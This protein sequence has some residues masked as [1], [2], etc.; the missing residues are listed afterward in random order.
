MLFV[1]LFINKG[2]SS[3]DVPV[4]L[5]CL[6]EMLKKRRKQVGKLQRLEI[7]KSLEDSNNCM[8][9]QAHTT[10]ILF[11]LSWPSVW[12]AESSHNVSL[13]TVYGVSGF[14]G[15][16]F[17][18]QTVVHLIEIERLVK[19]QFFASTQLFS[20]LAPFHYLLLNGS[21]YVSGK[22]PTYPSPK[23]TFCP[24]WEVSV[25]VGLGE[26]WVGSTPI[27]RSSSV[28]ELDSI[29]NF[30]CSMFSQPNDHF[31]VVDLVP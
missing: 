14:L 27:C 1:R 19:E 2:F 3:Q 6:E 20:S 29:V 7:W 12:L 8:T 15:K 25:N 28:F 9:H 11:A 30:V 18:L 22:L 16:F 24:K 23:P 10:A 17:W 21:L 26:G 5:Q 13:S 31:S 4:V